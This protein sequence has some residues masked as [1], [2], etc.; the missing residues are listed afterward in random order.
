MDISFENETCWF[1]KRLFF[2]KIPPSFVTAQNW[3]HGIFV[4][5]VNEVLSFSIVKLKE[6]S[7]KET[8]V[9]F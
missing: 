8:L 6:T 4:Q 1:A 3:N 2:G 9:L 5:A 7:R